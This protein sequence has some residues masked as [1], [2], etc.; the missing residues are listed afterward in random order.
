M[1]N[2]AFIGQPLD[3]VDGP[4]KVSGQATYAAEHRFEQPPLV[5][6]IVEATIPSGRIK[7]LD[8]SAAEA[9]TGVSA[10]LTHHNAPE[11]TPLGE[12]EDEGR[13]TQSRAMLSDDRIRYHGFPVALVVADTLENA[14]HAAELIEVSYEPDKGAVTTVGEEADEVP[15]ELDG[16]MEPDVSKGDFD[17]VYGA[18]DVTLDVTYTTPNQAAAAMEPHAA[19]ADFDGDR[20]FVAMSVQLVAPSVKA[21]ALI[22]T[23]S[24]C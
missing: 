4:L 20:L 9:S 18:A 22:R 3:R 11:Q 16:G 19:I 10:V 8:T 17:Q 5:G 21:C 24:G 14:R 13:F 12:P 23:R 7:H 2:P 15:D 1:T 6:W